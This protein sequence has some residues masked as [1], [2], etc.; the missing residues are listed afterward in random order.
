[1]MGASRFAYRAWKEHSL[2]G[3]MGGQGKPVIILGAGE[4][5]INL[6]K[7]LARSEAWQVV[8]LLDDDKAIHGRQLLNAKVLGAIQDLSKF[9]K[10]YQV[11]HVIVAMPLAE[12]KE[13]REAVEV[14]N[15]CGMTVLTVP[16]FDDLMSGKVSVSQIRKVEVEDLLGR[17]PVQLDTLGLH[18]MIEGHAILVSGAGGSIGSELCR[19]ILKYHPSKLV[20]VDMAEYSLYRIEQEFSQIELHDATEILYVTASVKNEKRVKELLS[21]YQPTVV[22]HA[23]AY[24]HVPLMENT[25][26]AEALSNNVLGTQVLANACKEANVD[27]FVLIS[28]D[29]AVNPTNV[30]GVSKRLAEM[31]CQGLQGEKGNKICHC[32][33][34]ECFR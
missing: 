18:E 19:Q 23:A 11:A 10:K 6:V 2:Y 17:E 9:A 15:Q 34:W 4:A 20:C 13:R 31:V 32:S 24:K 26:V 21:N 28:T 22:F 1:M 33:V 30:M 14:A 5:A 16:A 12:H 27:K 25:N 3:Q 29:K 7:D 8:G